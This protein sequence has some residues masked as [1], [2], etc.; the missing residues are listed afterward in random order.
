MRRRLWRKG[1]PGSRLG[2]MGLRFIIIRKRIDITAVQFQSHID[3]VAYGIVC[4]QLVVER[5]DT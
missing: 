2:S 1:A 4:R 5:A 3:D